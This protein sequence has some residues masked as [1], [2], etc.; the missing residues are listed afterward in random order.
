MN[1]VAASIQF[2]DICKIIREK[3]EILAKAISGSN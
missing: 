2:P 3:D 1:S